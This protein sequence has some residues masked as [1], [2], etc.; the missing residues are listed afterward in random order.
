MKASVFIDDLP[1]RFLM[2]PILFMERNWKIII[3]ISNHQNHHDAIL[4]HSIPS[5]K[6]H[7]IMLCF[8]LR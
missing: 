8:A 2:L 1:N 4:F 6:S 5:I 3:I 7:N